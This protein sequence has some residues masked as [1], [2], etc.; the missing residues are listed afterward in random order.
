LNC[1]H[2]WREKSK[3]EKK[4]SVAQENVLAATKIFQKTKADKERNEGFIEWLKKT[5]TVQQLNEYLITCYKFGFEYG[6][7][8][9]EWI[10]GGDLFVR[11]EA[12]RQRSLIKPVEFSPDGVIVIN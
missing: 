7:L 1:F 5:E 6:Y 2:N 11:A 9:P 3:A 12:L 4:N 10:F 8:H